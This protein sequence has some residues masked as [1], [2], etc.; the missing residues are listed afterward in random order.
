MIKT[1][2]YLCT[3]PDDVRMTRDYFTGLMRKFRHHSSVQYGFSAKHTKDILEY[4]KSVG[5]DKDTIPGNLYN[6]PIQ[7]NTE[8]T[9][10]K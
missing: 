10:V 7:W 4:R 9:Y 8:T 6:L 2:E 5:A 3:V 1:R